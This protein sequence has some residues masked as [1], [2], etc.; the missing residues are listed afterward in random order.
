MNLWMSI[1]ENVQMM[2]ENDVMYQEM[3]VCDAPW[4]LKCAENAATLERVR[5]VSG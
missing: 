2:Q 4:P 3:A 1:V 5:Q